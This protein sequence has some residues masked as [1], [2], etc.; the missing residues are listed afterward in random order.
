MTKRSTPDAPNQG[1]T[2]PS[3]DDLLTN[4]DQI[5]EG[6]L[7]EFVALV[8]DVLHLAKNAG[9]DMNDFLLEIEAP[10]LSEDVRREITWRCQDLLVLVQRLLDLSNERFL[11]RQWRSE[12]GGSEGGGSQEGRPN[13]G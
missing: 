7:R 1:A 2:P 10:E 12:G 9:L 4:A 13:R 5:P 8:V 6:T 3:E 11:L